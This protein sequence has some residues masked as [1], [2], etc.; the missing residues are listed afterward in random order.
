MI[1]AGIAVASFTGALTALALNFAPN[2]FAASEIMFWLLGS[3]AD[4]SF[5]HVG[6]AAP[7]MAAGAAMLFAQA[8]AYDALTLGEAAAATLGFDLR[9]VAGWT[10][11]GVALGVGAATAVAGAIG[12]VGLATPHLVRRHVAHR[13]GAVLGAS[14]LAGATLT[15]LADI[16]ARLIAPAEEIKLGVLTALLGAP[17]FV[18]LIRQHRRRG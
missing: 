17:F 9:R 6:L 16:A 12:F 1:L 14:A 18:H 15:L 8:R 13:P 10:V 2:P 4:R 11:L 3:L 7:F 5:E